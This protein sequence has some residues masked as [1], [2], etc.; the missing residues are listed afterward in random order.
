MAM[1]DV[2][3]QAVVADTLRAAF[4]VEH[5][6]GHGAT[7]YGCGAEGASVQ[8]TYGGEEYE[9]TCDEIPC[10][11]QREGKVTYQQ[12]L[13]AGESVDDKAAEGTHGQRREGVSAQYDS[14]HSLAGRECVAQV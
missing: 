13:L 12:H 14:Y 9:R 5:V 6:Y 4:G 3:A 8:C 11:E 10:E 1:A 2:V 7:G